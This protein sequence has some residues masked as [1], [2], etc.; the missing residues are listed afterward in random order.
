MKFTFI[1]VTQLHLPT[2][3]KCWM[4]AWFMV[5]LVNAQLVRLDLCPITSSISVTGIVTYHMGWTPY[6][7][8][9]N[10][11]QNWFEYSFT[12]KINSE[13]KWGRRMFLLFFFFLVL[14][15]C[16]ILKGPQTPPDLKKKTFLKKHQLLLECNKSC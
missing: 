6:G 4:L 1:P 11:I 5:I 16:H 9:N 7:K 3:P 13:H 10:K 8:N 15:C 12:E 2:G 14:Q